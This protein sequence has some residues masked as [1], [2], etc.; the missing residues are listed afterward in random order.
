MIDIPTAALEIL[1][2]RLTVRPYLVSMSG[3][4]A[5]AVL[6]LSYPLPFN[7]DINLEHYYM[8]KRKF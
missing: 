4:T 1:S 8:K 5:F 2:G 6:A 3:G 7:A